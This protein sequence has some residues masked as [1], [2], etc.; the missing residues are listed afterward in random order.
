MQEQSRTQEAA[1]MLATP[2]P[3]PPL[4]LPPSQPL[5]PSLPVFV[6]HAKQPRKELIK[7][8]AILGR[9]VERPMEAAAVAA[10][11][12]AGVADECPG[13][14]ARGVGVKN[15]RCQRIRASREAGS[16]Y[17]MEG[18]DDKLILNV[19][20]MRHETYINTVRAFPVTRLYKLMEPPTPGTP[21]AQGPPIRECFFDRNPELCGYVLGYYHTRQLH[22]PANVCP[23][24]GIE[25]LG[26]RGSTSGILLLTQT[27]WQGD[28]NPGLSVLGGL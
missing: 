7:P 23:R 16:R 19:G 12:A 5:V 1:T 22:C 2:P 24:G 3:T 9:P 8:K 17:A 15:H 13:P 21:A 10:G 28:Q 26:S 20:G 6:S 14:G 4:A 27:E 18:L 11:D 25:L